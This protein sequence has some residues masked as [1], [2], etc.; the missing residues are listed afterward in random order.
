MSH[1]VNSHRAQNGVEQGASFHSISVFGPVI[2]RQYSLLLVKLGLRGYQL[3][4]V[5]GTVTLTNGFHM[6]GVADP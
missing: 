6:N 5:N 4:Y 2:D 1:G 3:V